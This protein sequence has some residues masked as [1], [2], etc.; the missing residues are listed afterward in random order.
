MGAIY[1]NRNLYL[2]TSSTVHQY[3][4]RNST[5]LFNKLFP[6]GDVG[7]ICIQ[8]YHQLPIYLKSIQNHSTFKF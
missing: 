3:N 4:T 2:S 8:V 7:G 6:K 1:A 5:N